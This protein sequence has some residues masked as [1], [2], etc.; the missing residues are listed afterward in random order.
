VRPEDQKLG[1]EIMG[2][3]LEERYSGIDLYPRAWDWNTVSGDVGRSLRQ[4]IEEESEE[5]MWI[6]YV[7]ALD[8][9]RSCQEAL[10]EV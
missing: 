5:S 10:N 2:Y 8:C 7:F 9:L 1:I 3:L 4:G 6:R